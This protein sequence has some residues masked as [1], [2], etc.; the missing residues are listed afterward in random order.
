MTDDT[1]PRAEWAR[2]LRHR[3]RPI[4]RN[5]P[6]LAFPTVEARDAAADAHAEVTRLRAEVERLRGLVA[7]AVPGIKAAGGSKAP[8][9][10]AEADALL[11][12]SEDKTDG[13]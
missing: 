12:P 3:R 11:S 13:R 1:K 10:L 5:S 2:I 6:V 9:W 4:A 7:R 8:D